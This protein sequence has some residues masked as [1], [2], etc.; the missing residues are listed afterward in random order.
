[1]ALGEKYPFSA[2]WAKDKCPA[3]GEP[4]D[5]SDPVIYNNVDE[6]VHYRC[7]NRRTEATAAKNLVV[8]Q[9]CF[10]TSCDC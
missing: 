8:C 7:R 4:W 6:V 5:Q 10:L 2:K 9:K 1:M 3:C